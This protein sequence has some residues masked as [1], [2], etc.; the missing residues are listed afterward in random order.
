MPAIAILIAGL[1]HQRPLKPLRN[2]SALLVAGVS[3][4]LAVYLGFLAGDLSAIDWA[5]NDRRK[6]INGG[7]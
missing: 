3:V 2:L 1:L 4:A 7:A 5:P 6:I